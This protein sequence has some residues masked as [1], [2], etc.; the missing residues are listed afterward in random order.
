M[1]L[2]ASPAAQ[3]MPRLK[4]RT[5]HGFYESFG[6]QMIM[7]LYWPGKKTSEEI[8]LEQMEYWEDGIEFGWV[9]P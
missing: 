3:R 5:E 2:N 1:D 8:L 6:G 7:V 9:K 4:L